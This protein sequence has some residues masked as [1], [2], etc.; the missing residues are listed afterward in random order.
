MP[1]EHKNTLMHIE[2][3]PEWSRFCMDIRPEHTKYAHEDEILFSCY[4]LYRYQRTEKSNGQRIIKLQLL[5]YHKF[6]DYRRNTIRYL[7]S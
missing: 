4:N 5:D 2:I 7:H 6:F 1:F 3:S